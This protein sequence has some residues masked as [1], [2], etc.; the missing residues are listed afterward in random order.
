VKKNPSGDGAGKRRLR[1]LAVPA[2]GTI[3]SILT[4]ASV[5]FLV[6]LTLVRGPRNLSVQAQEKNA[7]I[8]PPAVGQTLTTRPAALPS[9]STMV[10]LATWNVRDCAA[11]DD[12]SKTRIPLHDYV[13][14]SIK[15]AR[16]DIVVLEEIQSDQAKGGDIALLSV[17]L[18]KEGW[19]MPFVAVVNAKGEDDLAIFS[20]YKIEESGSVIKPASGD[21]WPREGIFASIDLGGISLDVY[22]FHFKAMGDAES[23]KT[24]RAQAKAIGNHL[25]SFYGESLL[26]K[27]IVLAGDFNTANASDF[28]EKNSTLSALRLTDDTIKA[29]DFLD[30]NYQF[31]RTD[32]TFVDSRYAS[33]L[34]HLFL[35]PALSGA[36]DKSHVEIREPVPGPGKIPV[37]DHRIVLAELTLPPAR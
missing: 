29:N 7:P 34:D 23:E 30:A 28:L 35:S 14:R 26:T 17:A 2:A 32:P 3:A 18:A 6:V 15:E 27:P 37:S 36:M 31:R 11:W 8:Q 21:P 1:S 33:I 16:V 19:A 10:R 22:G 9:D 12:A 24:R 13:A 4:V 20:R 5:V 25:F